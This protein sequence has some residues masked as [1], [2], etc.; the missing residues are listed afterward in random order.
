MNKS[1]ITHVQ[2]DA[3]VSLQELVQWVAHMEHA[4]SI[5]FTLKILKNVKRKFQRG[6]FFSPFSENYKYLWH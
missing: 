5:E 4:G 3:L 1:E 2:C 6:S